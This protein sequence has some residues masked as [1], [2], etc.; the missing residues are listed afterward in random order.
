MKPI[1]C[2]YC[3]GNDTKIAVFEKIHNR[4]KILRIASSRIPESKRTPAQKS[5][6]KGDEF[7]DDVSFDEFGGGLEVED[8]MGDNVGVAA[9]ALKGIKLSKCN[10]I[11]V[12][13][14][15]VANFH[16]YEGD[17]EQDKRKIIDAVITDI[18]DSKGIMVDPTAVDVI[19]FTNNSMLSVFLEE[20]V[21]CI[22]FINALASYNRRRY[23]HI[24]TIK[25]ADLSLAYY[26]S[27]TT[28]FFPE[29]FSLIIYIG[30][31][32]SKLIFLEGQKLKHLGTTLDIGTN[33]LSTYDVYFSKILLEMENGGI[34]KL[35]NIIL[36]GEDRSENLLLSFY[37]TFPE[38][39][40]SELK[41]DNLIT[42]DLDQRS[43]NGLS[44]F[45]IPIS[46]ALE[47]FDEID[48][49]YTGINI[50]PRYVQDRQKVFQFGWH[51]FVL[52]PIIFYVTFFFTNNILTNFDE[53][54]ALD[55]EITDL[56]QRQIK[57]QVI[58]NQ[59]DP[60]NEKINSF[61]FTQ[62]I[63]DSA[64][65]GAEMW[66]N[67]LDDISTFIERRRNFWV[68]KL[69]TITSN[70]I[71]LIGYSLSRSVLTEFAKKKKASLLR[72]IL[73]EPLRE[74]NAFIYTLNFKIGDK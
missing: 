28:K 3:E 16:I 46:V 22:N 55:E 20:N 68:T 15:P 11:P 41:F 59:M 57:N 13:T 74:K 48:K 8:E 70:E 51:A 43:M 50:L 54:E 49:G 37:G 61:D 4:I 62:S 45:S 35:D 42:E 34:P 44:A 17:R 23:Y 12:V 58:V 26:V 60:L 63:I 72:N 30:R 5:D 31:E 71:Q 27:Q 6:F 32:Y 14:E 52:L 24:P 33:N 2:V 9:A 53:I 19:D 29:D 47:Y 21:P 36:C 7:G 65:A 69:E 64:A 66:G 56:T 38:A 1:V 10:F 40:V 18:E 25:T 67:A 73:Y 39:N